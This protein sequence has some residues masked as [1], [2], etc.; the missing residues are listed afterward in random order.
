MQKPPQ[1]IGIIMDGNRRWARSRGLASYKG[2]ETGAET[3]R[4][5]MLYAKKIG[6][7]TLTVYAFS[8]E[9]WRRTKRE[10][11]FLLTLMK[12]FIKEKEQELRENKIRVHIIG[13][14]QQFSKNIREGLKTLE[15][16]TTPGAEFVLNVALSYGG[17]DEIIRGAKQYLADHGSL[18]GLTEKNFG[19]VL[20]LAGQAEPDLVIRTGGEMRI[21]NFL[22]WHLAYSELYF[23]KTLWPDFS[24]RDL[25]AAI[26]DYHERERR[27]G[28]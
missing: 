1:H 14:I 26:A 25:R 2:H 17:R 12:R 4:Q 5:V 21:S 11:G 6:V 15:E 7:K 27:F 10:V 3:L 18:R 13:D 16:R 22:L 8:S 23:T 20:D 19:S 9:N 24:E 28:K